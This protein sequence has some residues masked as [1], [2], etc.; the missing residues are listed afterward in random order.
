[1]YKKHEIQFGPSLQKAKTQID[2]RTYFI[3]AV[4]TLAKYEGVKFQINEY[5]IYLPIIKEIEF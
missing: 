1:M 3:Y 4:A 2:M 5:I